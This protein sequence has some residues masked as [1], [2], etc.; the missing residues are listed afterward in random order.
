MSDDKPTICKQ[1]ETAVPVSVVLPTY[2]RGTLVTR[3]IESVLHQ[4]F[5]DLELIIIVDGS[6]DDTMRRL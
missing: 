4:T 6:T 5:T 3:A 2:N 1:A